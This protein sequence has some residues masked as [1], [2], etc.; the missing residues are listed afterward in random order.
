[1]LLHHY[2]VIITSLLPHYSK[3]L[4]QVIMSLLLRIMHFRCFHYYM[5]ITHYCH[6][7]LLL[8]V[9]DSRTCRC[10]RILQLAARRETH[11]LPH[12]QN[13]EGPAVACARSRA[14]CG[15]GERVRQGENTYAQ[16]VDMNH[17]M[18]I[19]V[20]HDRLRDGSPENATCARGTDRANACREK[21]RSFRRFSSASRVH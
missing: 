5:V 15:G 14:A 17:M 4:K 8:H 20:A 21:S 16:M 18:S 6:Y 7:Y 3:W 11:W 10:S 13:V 12:R 1:M 2:Y 19:I 9:R